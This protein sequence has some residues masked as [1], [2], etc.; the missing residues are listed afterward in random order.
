MELCQYQSLIEQ[1]SETPFEK[2]YQYLVD[3]F[4]AI[5]DKFSLESAQFIANDKFSRV[6]F[7]PDKFTAQTKQQVLFLY[8]PKYHTSRNTFFNG[9]INA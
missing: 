2:L 8:N 1:N 3:K 4:F 6:R 9:A 5:N 7:S